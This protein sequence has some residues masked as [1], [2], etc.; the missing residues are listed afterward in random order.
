MPSSSQFTIK[1]AVNS[2]GV[3]S[4]INSAVG[5]FSK[6]YS[7]AQN[8]VQGFLALS[9]VQFAKNTIKET[10]ELGGHLTDLAARSKM[11]V[12]DLQA[13][14]FAVEQN[15]GNVDD[16]VTAM[17][18][19]SSAQIDAL[20]GNLDLRASF[21]RYGVTLKDLR[22]LNQGQV[23]RKTAA[24]IGS[25][26]A[27]A[28]V[29]DDTIALLGK[30][31]DVLLPAFRNGFSET[32]DEAERLG[33]VIKTKVTDE[34]DRA[35]DE[36]DILNKKW[37]V[38]KA[39]LIGTAIGNVIGNLKEIA[40]FSAAGNIGGL[41]AKSITQLTGNEDFGRQVGEAMSEAIFNHAQGLDAAA[42]KEND[43]GQS[44]TSEV[45]KSK[46]GIDRGNFDPSTDKL[47][48]IGGF[49]GGS[50]AVSIIPQQHL[51]EARKQTIHLA[52]IPQK[53]EKTNAGLAE[54]KAQLNII[55]IQL[56]G[57]DE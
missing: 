9:A 45:A 8:V 56:R 25:A 33:L 10:I 47:L 34:L 5:Q 49:R 17:K 39:N 46:A 15:G 4:G 53:L 23:F 26:P 12:E 20:K 52:A 11:T 14:S 48:R 3:T 19:L 2:S 7:T 54:L 55:G 24:G 57:D 31:G 22:T 41:F 32:A 43:N 38:F 35:G 30:A 6:L 36:I 51:D 42:K 27:S 44:S 18:K 21:A 28:L 16:L 1:L 37:T 40:N 29:T 50:G 13:M